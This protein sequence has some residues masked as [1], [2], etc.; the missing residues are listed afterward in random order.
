MAI[1]LLRLCGPMQSWGIQSRFTN[2]DTA[3]EPSKSGVIGLLCAALGKPRDESVIPP[4]DHPGW[5][6]LADLSRLKMGIRVDHP[7]V[8]KKDYQTAG[9]YHLK[10]D[11]GYGVPPADGTQRR[12]ITSD[13]FYL[14]D[15]VFLVALQGDKEL[16]KRLYS[17][18]QRPVWQL[19]LGRK[20]FV[21]SCPVWLQDGFRLEEDDLKTALTSYPYFCSVRR[22]PDVL[23]L[24]IEVGYGQGEIVK[25]D[26]PLSFVSAARRFTLRYLRMDE[27]AAADLPPA[28]EALC[29]CRC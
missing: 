14:A 1:L 22:P 23:R 11:S 6:S 10:K 15:A 5:P 12:A 29:I 4:P 19:Y 7:G 24:E 26:Q 3:L 8:V 2:R 27:V 21:P 18:L 16:L 20:A 9:G 28:E 17:A 13:R 25:P